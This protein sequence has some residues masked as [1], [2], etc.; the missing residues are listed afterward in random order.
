M[1][2]G[3]ALIITLLLGSLACGFITTATPSSTRPS[4]PTTALPSSVADATPTAEP[5][6]PPPGDV[7]VTQT[8]SG[9]LPLPTQEEPTK[10]PYPTSV[11]DTQFKRAIEQI[12]SQVSELRGLQ[13]KYPVPFVLLSPD[14]LQKNMVNDFWANNTAEDIADGVI[15]LSILGLLEPD[16]DFGGFYIDLLSEQV[17]GY[18]DN[19]MAEMFVV[20]GQG[21]QGYEHLTY[22]HEYTHVLQDQNY[23]IKYGLNYNDDV[24]ETDSERCTAILALIE[25]DASLSEL[26]WFQ[27]YAT[28]EDQQQVIDFYSTLSSPVYDN[29]PA[30]LKDDFV[31]PYVQGLTFVQ[32]L[33]DQG[34]WEA[35]D[36][37]YQDPPASTEQI[38]HPELYPSDTPIKVD[39]PDLTAALGEGW[40]EVFKG[41]VGEW[42][43]YLILAR[44]ADSNAR[45]DD[46][47]AQ[48]AAAGWGGDLY[49]VLHNDGA[50]STALVMKTIWDAPREAAEFSTAFQQY[51]NIRFEAA[52]TQQGD[53]LTWSYPGGYSS[54]YHSGDTTIWIIAPDSTAAQTISDLVQP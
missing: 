41:Q 26:V 23:D 14:E 30:F 39:L 27:Y 5:L 38:L 43:T 28:A 3:Y 4:K 25:G 48:D 35:V 10:T 46:T 33:Y 17:A 29:A 50:N 44:A 51:A 37:A 20:Q 45:L 42:Y 9:N 36:A 16:F 15:E 47:T 54:F 22:S 34:G 12:Q 8:P 6:V 18:Y 53:T 11:L 21:F 49:T 19:E 32:S 40:R 52:A 24:C 7:T 1:R 31:F 13:L 2:R